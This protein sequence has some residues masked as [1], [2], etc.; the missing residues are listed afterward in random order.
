[1]N[2]FGIPIFI[3]F[4]SYRAF[5]LKIL[6]NLTLTDDILFQSWLMT[7]FMYIL[8]IAIIIYFLLKIVIF[9]KNR[10]F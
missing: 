5:I 6:P 8:F 4:V 1:M 3:S 7:N 9:I 2:L 10:M